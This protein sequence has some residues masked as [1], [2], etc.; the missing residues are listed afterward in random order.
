[1][2]DASVKGKVMGME[3]SHVSGRYCGRI[4]GIKLNEV[5]GKPAILLVQRRAGSL[6]WKT[7]K[8]SA[9]NATPK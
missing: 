2:P 1:M 8:F 9:G 6:Q 5:A 3:V 4:V 7:A